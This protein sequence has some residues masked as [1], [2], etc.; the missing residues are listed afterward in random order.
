[1][2]ID[3]ST[4]SHEKGLDKAL[5][6]FLSISNWSQPNVGRLAGTKTMNQVTKVKLLSFTTRHTHT[7]T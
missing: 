7:H 3:D 1:M 5:E 4:E 6:G 2:G